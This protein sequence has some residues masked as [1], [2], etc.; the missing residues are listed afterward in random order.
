MGLQGGLERPG[1]LSTDTLWQP[2]QGEGNDGSDFRDSSI[3]SFVGR[4]L[5]IQIG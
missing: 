1:H 5:R 2:L 3:F 4:S